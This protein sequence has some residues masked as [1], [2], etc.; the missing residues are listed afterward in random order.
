MILFQLNKKNTAFPVVDIVKRQFGVLG[1]SVEGEEEEG[2][3]IPKMYAVS[4][5]TEYECVA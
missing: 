1:E 5:M 4:I 3:I 2:R